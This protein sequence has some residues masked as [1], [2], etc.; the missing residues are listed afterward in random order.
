MIVVFVVVFCDGIPQMSVVEGTTMS[1]VC[2]D[3]IPSQMSS[4]WFGH[5]ECREK[6][7]VEIAVDSS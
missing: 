5:L 3:L 7:W 1:I 2:W 4:Q 6:I